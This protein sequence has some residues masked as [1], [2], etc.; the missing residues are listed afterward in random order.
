MTFCG[1]NEYFAPEI[2]NGLEQTE[3]VDIWTMG[4]LLY[5]VAHKRSPFKTET[6]AR[7]KTISTSLL[8]KQALDEDLKKICKLCLKKN[9][10][11]RPTA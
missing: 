10:D 3:K 7:L 11:E 4:V 2:L 9:P 6:Y 1:T 5:E 8:I